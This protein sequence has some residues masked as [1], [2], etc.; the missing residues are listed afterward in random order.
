MR[1]SV[2]AAVLLSLAWSGP[3]DA[4]FPRLHFLDPLKNALLLPAVAQS[5]QQLE[6]FAVPEPT[7]YKNAKPLIGILSQA[8]HYCPGK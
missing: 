5:Q 7:Q 6:S 8:C 3:V 1:T 4:A 2:L